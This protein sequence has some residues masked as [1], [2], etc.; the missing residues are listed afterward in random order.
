[1][2]R[3][4]PENGA[5]EL[6][7]AELRLNN[8]PLPLQE[9][10]RRRP[11][12]DV[13]RLLEELDY[14]LRPPVHERKT[15]PYGAIVALERAAKTLP[16]LP[17]ADVP[18]D[19]GLSRQM[20]NGRHSFL[21]FVGEAGPQLASFEIPVDGELG[22]IRLAQ[23]TDVVAIQRTRDGVVRIATG[24][25][26]VLHENRRW[27]TKPYSHAVAP[28][29]HRSSPQAD[30][31]RLHRILEFCFHL[32]GASHVGATLVWQLVPFELES[33]VAVDG[34][35]LNATEQVH[36]PLIQNL[37]AQHDGAA[38]LSP[39]GDLLKI[40]VQLR[41][42]ERA[43]G[44]IV[45]ERGL[46][47]TSAKRF[48]FDNER[49]LVFTVSEDGPVTVFS[50]GAAVGS[51][52]WVGDSPDAIRKY[53]PGKRDSVESSVSVMKCDRCGKYSTV[54]IVIVYGWRSEETGDCAICGHEI[55]SARCFDIRSW[56]KK[57]L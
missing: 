26:V 43:Q 49:V 32:L 40:G 37:L 57:V 11:N 36:R 23:T 13:A 51:L 33:G 6:L 53:V 24:K 34:L 16:L 18:L 8:V 48:S 4:R 39:E 50:D 15:P 47:H 30:G 5:I 10:N 1:M 2:A 22:L 14:A 7:K 55:V 42:S 28:Q 35:R 27:R 46:R 3:P 44:L 54:E 12:L 38:V 19:I 17:R 21:A 9:K 45:Q 31:V 41:A 29:V 52:G 25:D 20:A 56:P